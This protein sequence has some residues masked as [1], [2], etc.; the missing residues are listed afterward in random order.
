LGCTRGVLADQPGSY[1]VHRLIGV[2]RRVSQQVLAIDW[3][4]KSPMPHVIVKL[5]SGRSEK[6]KANLAAEVCKAIVTV[7]NCDESSVSVAIE[8]VQ[9]GEWA[10]KVY[11]PDIA[12]NMDRIYKKPGYEP[13]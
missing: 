12:G 10:G 13:L 2:S 7:L 1:T 9:S 11:R 4:G 8:D 3:K 6:Q 5:L